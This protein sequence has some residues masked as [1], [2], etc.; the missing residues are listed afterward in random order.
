MEEITS[1]AKENFYKE[2]IEAGSEIRMILSDTWQDKM[3]KLY[4]IFKNLFG[5]KSK[6]FRTAKDILYYQGG[7]PRETSPAKAK[8]LADRIAGFYQVLAYVDRTEQFD[9]FLAERGLKLEFIHEDY[10]QDFEDSIDNCFSDEK[11]IKRVKNLF[12]ELFGEDL[13]GDGVTTL[14]MMLDESL[15]YQCEICQMAD[16][17]KFMGDEVEEETKIKKGHYLKTVAIKVKELRQ[18][19]ISKDI[20]KVEEEKQSLEDSISIYK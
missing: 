7:Y 10:K 20:N 6:E 19:D 5:Q 1:E 13:P 16:E 9:R 14:N 11:K 3:K 18:K 17:V 4:K 15:E 8:A 2:K 12:T